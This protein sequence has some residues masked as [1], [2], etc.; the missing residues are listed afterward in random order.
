M[1]NTLELSGTSL[2]IEQLW[3]V[4]HAKFDVV[5]PESIIC[6]LDNVRKHVE[7]LIDLG[8]PVYG[9]NTG[10]GALAEHAISKEDLKALQRNLILSH[11]VGVGEPL[12]SIE[13][14]A[15]MLLR[16]NTLAQ[17]YSGIRS[18]VLKTLVELL[19]KG[20]TPH[21]PRKG[22][23][24]ASGDLAP[25]SHLALLL[26]GEGDAYIHGQPMSAREALAQAKIAAIVLE[27]REGLALINGTQAMV[28]V[29]GLA[30]K[31][32]HDLVMLANIIGACTHAAIG[33]SPTPFDARIHEVRPHKG[34]ISCA[35]SIRAV[36]GISGRCATSTQGHGHLVQDPYSLRCMPQVH[37]AT[38]DTIN[39]VCG[40]L[41]REI[42]S[43]TD[44][45]LIFC[46]ETEKGTDFPGAIA[47]DACLRRHDKPTGSYC[48]MH[49][50]AMGSYCSR[51]DKAMGSCGG[52]D[53]PEGNHVEALSGGNFH[54]QPIAFALDFL[55]IA[56]SA[57]AN[58]SERR[59]EQMLN[60]KLSGGLPAFL[61]ENPGINSGY[62]IPQVTAAALINE[63][64]VLCYPASADSIPTSAA[65]E[66]HVSMGMTSA[67]KLCTIIENTTMVLATELLCAAQ[68]LDLQQE[69]RRSP[70]VEKVRAILREGVPFAPQDRLFMNDMAKS[71]DLLKSGA[72][73]N[74]IKELLGAK[75]HSSLSQVIG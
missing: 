25:L 10:F 8:K 64:K 36:L 74:E 7:R 38:L 22:S 72:L 63:N 52:Y 68:A 24:G 47:L 61:A 51:H 31:R 16:A 2:S 11:A 56:V 53:K 60:P 12:S 42:N 17:G 44:N 27:A 23:V 62:M 28:A 34:Q 6:R 37:G 29:G 40:I 21:V 32:A 46:S 5:T 4:A 43:A 67:N 3:E 39:Y 30:T 33:S 50:K 71:A 48:S 1:H 75:N 45:P 49:D 54:G 58:I 26:I 15:L 69:K 20:V 18:I 19:N 35:E 14:R 66:D 70:A 13:A 57:L 41:E 59:I 73:L 65:R 9:L 55:A